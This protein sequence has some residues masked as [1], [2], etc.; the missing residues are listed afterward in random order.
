MTEI[1]KQKKFNPGQVVLAEI[2]M[3]AAAAACGVSPSTVW[4]WAQD[5]KRGTGGIVPG[6]YHMLLLNAARDS[7]SVLTAYDLVYGRSR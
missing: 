5:N 3:T 2:G 7:G 1:I 6:R 4:R